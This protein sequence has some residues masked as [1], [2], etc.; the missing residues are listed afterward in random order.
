MYVRVWAAVLLLE[1]R[2]STDEMKNYHGII[3]PSSQSESQMVVS[4]VISRRFERRTL[5]LQT[6]NNSSA[7][8]KSELPKKIPGRTV[9]ASIYKVCRYC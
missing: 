4:L 3:V 9:N 7:L 2:L 5:Y 1:N 6:G 8:K